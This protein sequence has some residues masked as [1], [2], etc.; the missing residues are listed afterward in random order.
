MHAGTLKPADLNEALILKTYNELEKGAA[1]GYG[2]DWIKLDPKIATT[3]SKLQENL[4]LFS[5][6]KSYQQLKEMNSFLVDEK[7]KIRT[8]SEFKRKVDVVHK[9][10]NKNYLETEY[11]TS[12]RSAQA[13]RQWKD[14]EENADLF[15]NLIYTTVGDDKV[16]EDHVKLSGIIKAINDPFW[17]I[18]YPPNGFRDRCDARPTTKA[19]TEIKSLPKQAKGFENN[20]GKTN[21]IFTKSHP[22]FTMPKEAKKNVDKSLEKFIKDREEKKND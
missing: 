7:G 16:R 20:V 10:Y 22:Y 15:P 18:W 3:V 2:K 21:T 8:F 1:T 17:D 19:V 11:I 14:I 5:A 9:N 12:K 6:A 13:V 4:Y